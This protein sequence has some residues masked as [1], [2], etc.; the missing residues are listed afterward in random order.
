MQ[1]IKYDG[2][3]KGFYCYFADN[4]DNIKLVFSSFFKISNSNIKIKN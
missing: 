2:Y 4:H 1:L 3:V